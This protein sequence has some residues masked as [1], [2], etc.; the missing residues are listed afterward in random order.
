MRCAQTARLFSMWRDGNLSPRQNEQFARHL[1]ECPGCAEKLAGYSLEMDG[2]R[3]ER[4]E[5][6]ESFRRGWRNRLAGKT[7]AGRT[8][9]RTFAFPVWVAAAACVV[10][11]AAASLASGFFGG[12]PR[13]LSQVGKA[14]NFE[15][16]QEKALSRMAPAAGG[17]VN[18]NFDSAA[19]KAAPLAAP[20]PSA[21]MGVAAVERKVMRSAS[22]SIE[23]RN[24]EQSCAIIERLTGQSGGFVRSS[25]VSR[26][27]GNRLTGQV[28]IAVPAGR[29]DEILGRLTQAGRI[30]QKSVTG[31][32]VTEEYVDLGARLKNWRTQES[33]LNLIMTRARNVEETLAV[34]NELARVREEI[35]RLT[36]RMQYLDRKTEFADIS[37]TVTQ[38]GSA[39]KPVWPALEA[40]REI[41]GRFLDSILSLV[42]VAVMLLP[43]GAAGYGIFVLIRRWYRNRQA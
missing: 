28:E 6:P 39:R 12:M 36:G 18:S 30:L 14:P 23:S 22:L 15:S 40:L 31:Q 42:S 20:A 3:E 11:V 16:V 10:L 2:L 7:V 19:T 32:D 1:E 34:Q 8:R 25:S 9:P 27:E 41:G 35:E 17:A 37:V 43:W 24:V 38:K 5:V 4:V 13:T 26:D 21:D 33:Q 29:F